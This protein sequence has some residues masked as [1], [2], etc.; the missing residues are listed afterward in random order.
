MKYSLPFKVE[1]NK[2]NL[3]EVI[4]Q[5]VEKD[6]IDVKI[7]LNHEDYYNLNIWNDESINAIPSLSYGDSQSNLSFKYIRLWNTLI[8]IE[9]LGL[10]EHIQNIKSN[11]LLIN[12]YETEIGEISKESCPVFVFCKFSDVIC[13]GNVRRF[14]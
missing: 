10:Y 8:T 7:S 13:Q 9:E 11:E 6:N 1:P 14:L 2:W 12:L 3:L 4:F 5:K